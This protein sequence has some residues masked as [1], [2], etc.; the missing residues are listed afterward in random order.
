MHEYYSDDVIL[1]KYKNYNTRIMLT[2]AEDNINNKFNQFIFYGKDKLHRIGTDEDNYGL[3]L[4]QGFGRKIEFCSELGNRQ[5]ENLLIVGKDE[6]MAMS[7]FE[8]SAMSL[9]YD[10]LFTDNDKTNTLMYITN[11]S[12]VELRDEIADFNYLHEVLSDN[13]SIKK[14]PSWNCKS[15]WKK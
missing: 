2:N 5:G 9:L 15:R 6:K 8:F 11:L 4:G 12:D 1:E 3:L 14:F 7:L 10:E 13:V